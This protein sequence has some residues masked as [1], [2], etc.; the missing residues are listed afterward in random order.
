MNKVR[1]GDYLK[2]ERLDG[3]YIDYGLIVKVVGRE[4][5][6]LEYN[7]RETILKTIRLDSEEIKVSEDDDFKIIDEHV[8]N[9]LFLEG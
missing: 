9:Q 2:I 3:Y 5:K 8:I 4:E 6:L 1:L 7:E